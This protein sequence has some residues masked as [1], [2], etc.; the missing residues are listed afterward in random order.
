MFQ[1]SDIR[2]RLQ[3]A[4]PLELPTWARSSRPTVPDRADHR[5]P[6]SGRRTTAPRHKGC[7][8]IWLLAWFAAGCATITPAR[9]KLPDELAVSTPLRVE[10]LGGGRSGDYRAGVYAGAFRRS[11]D[12]VSLAD[13][14]YSQNSG[15]VAFSLRAPAIEGALDATCGFSERILKLGPVEGALSPFSY[16]CDFSHQGRGIPA[17]FE[18]QGDDSW[19][20]MR[21]RRGEIALDREILRIRSVHQLQDTPF[22]S[23]TPIGYVFEANGAPVGSIELNGSPRIWLAVGISESRRRAVMA[24]ALA[25]ALLW[26]PASSS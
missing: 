3:G 25:L 7:L 20:G 2:K 11:A 15:R 6:Q 26:D 13:G 12:Q 18:L 4:G 24:G 5:P 10:G 8:K 1:T 19:S 22:R 17:R 23:P 16:R 21:A 9:M 14:F